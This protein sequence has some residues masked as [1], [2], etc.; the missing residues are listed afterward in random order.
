MGILDHLVSKRLTVIASNPSDKRNVHFT[1]L[2]RR[3]LKRYVLQP[4][5][6]ITDVPR[7]SSSPFWN[8]RSCHTFSNL[9]IAGLAQQLET[10]Y[11]PHVR[12]YL[13]RFAQL[14][15]MHKTIDVARGLA[16]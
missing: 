5:K 6:D 9:P 14:K 3:L 1:Y 8:V 13:R 16:R 10:S 2:G 15:P 12:L 11:V 4:P 7:M